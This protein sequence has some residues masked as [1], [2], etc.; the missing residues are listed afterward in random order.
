MFPLASIYP[1]F[2]PLETPAKPFLKNNTSENFGSMEMFS[3]LSIK[4]LQA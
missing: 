4:P 3:D 1:H 2:E